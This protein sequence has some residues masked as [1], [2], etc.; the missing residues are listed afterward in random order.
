[1]YT[2]CLESSTCIVSLS[3][4]VGL[5][6]VDDAV[7]MAGVSGLT[8]SLDFG[9]VTVVSE[10]TAYG[11]GWNALGRFNIGKKEEEEEEKETTR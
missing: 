5:G 6:H 2:L 3:S 8:W 9:S 10:L 7:A 4:D 1:M 11:G